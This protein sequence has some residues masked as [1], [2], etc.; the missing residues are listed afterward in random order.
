M[1]QTRLSTLHL[2]R[3]STFIRG[4]KPKCYPDP[5]CFSSP[6]FPSSHPLLY[7]LYDG[8]TLKSL[9]TVYYQF[10][11]YFII[12]DKKCSFVL[13]RVSLSASFWIWDTRP[14]GFSGFRARTSLNL[15]LSICEHRVSVFVYCLLIMPFSLKYGICVPSGS[16]I[17]CLTFS[18][19]PLRHSVCC[20]R[21][22]P[23]ELRDTM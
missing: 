11:I 20:P 23:P 3:G 5:S 18:S 10:P 13:G 19:S 9:G 8:S 7:P 14:S 22:E 6:F 2:N 1:D 21:V 15:I 4:R 17:D 12:N 16:I